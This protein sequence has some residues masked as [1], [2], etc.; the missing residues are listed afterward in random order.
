M[1]P[2]EIA[3]AAA[4]HGAWPKTDILPADAACFLP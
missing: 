3:K 1:L 2:P 4:P